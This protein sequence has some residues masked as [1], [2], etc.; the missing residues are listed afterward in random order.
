[1]HITNQKLS[2][3]IFIVD[4]S[5]NI[6]MEHDFHL[7]IFD[8]KEKLIILTPSIFSYLNI[9]MQHNVVFVV[10]ELTMSPP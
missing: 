2:L 7:M 9:S 1:M 4:H 10:N 3:D 8:F 6:I 5:Q